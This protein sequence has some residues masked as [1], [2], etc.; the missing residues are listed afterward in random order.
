MTAARDLRVRFG[1]AWIKAGREIERLTYRARI[2]QPKLLGPAVRGP[3]VQLYRADADFTTEVGFVNFLTFYLL[4]ADIGITVTATAYD[5]NGRRLGSGRH[6]LGRKQ[7]LQRPLAELVDAP[8]DAHG[9]FMIEAAYDAAAI[10]EIAFLGQT[11][12]QF[13]TLFVPTAGG[14]AAPQ[15]LHSHKIFQRSGVPYSPCRWE[16]PVIEHLAAVEAYSV[17]V[18]NSCRSKLTG[19]VELGG[20]GEKAAT[21]RTDYSVPGWGVAR[22]DLRLDALALPLDQPFRFAC[23]FDR[24]TP[25]RKP[26]L[27]RRFADG[28][29]TGNH[30]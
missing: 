26:I 3:L 1:K 21:W 28:S 11:A 18:V 30:S 4:D 17:F 25:H 19:R 23:D 22:V 9:L 15:I 16:S 13:M 27:F 8:L 10:D 29:I 24:R 2:A 7:A 12:P 6:R 14:A 5:R 20:L